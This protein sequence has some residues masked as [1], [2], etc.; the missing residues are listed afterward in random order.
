MPCVSGVRFA[1]RRI[2]YLFGGATLDQASNEALYVTRNGGRS[3]RRLR[4]GA[5]ALD[6]GGGRVARLVTPPGCSSLGCHDRVLTARV[7][8]NRWTTH[9]LPG[10][11]LD[12]LTTAM[13]GSG[14]DLAVQSYGNPA[15]GGVAKGVLWTSADAG[16]SFQ[17]RGEVCPQ[18]SL[19]SDSSGFRGEVDSRAVM[20]GADGSITVVCAARSSRK[21][22][23][24]VTAPDGAA[25]FVRQGQVPGQLIAAFTARTLLALVVPR[26]SARRGPVLMRTND[27]G[28][29]WR[30][31]AE[32]LD[33]A[34]P[35]AADVLSSRRALILIHGHA[36]LSTINGGRTWTRAGIDSQ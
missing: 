18:N 23:F 27:G 22:T 21:P 36:I 5:L 6:A 16:Q 11:Y 13:A 17:R 3:W 12:T 9:R 7:G 33:G 32:H 24:L 35:A 14:A 25:Q 28:Q 15:G 20:A 4:G 30:P 34:Q 26:H 19:A 10:P 29:S 8:A 1:T 31:V 2:G